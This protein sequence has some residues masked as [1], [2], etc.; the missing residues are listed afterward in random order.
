M[1]RRS[2]RTGLALVTVGFIAGAW[3]PAASAATIDRA[4]QR[5]ASVTIVHGV[6]GLVADV[7]VDGKQ[8]LSGFSPEQ[9]TAPLSLTPGKHRV[10]IRRSVSGANAAP[11]L[12][13]TLNLT[14]GEVGTAAVGLTSAGKP[15]LTMY[16]DTNAPTTSG[17][18]GHLAVRDIA[19]APPV[20]L[21]VNKKVVASSLVSPNAAST[22]VQAGSVPVGIDAADTKSQLV[23]PQNVP[24]LAGRST[25]LYLIGQASDHSLT[26]LAQTIKT[27]VTAAPTSVDT[28]Y[29]PPPGWERQHVL[30]QL[31]TDGL[32]AVL[33]LT[34]LGV[35]GAGTARWYRR[36]QTQSL[37]RAL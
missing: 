18:E 17:N 25:A 21:S 23:P 3:A 37:P 16:E 6:L 9:V 34:V 20:I 7:T 31:R 5:T 13:T 11:V 26:W 15:K 19:A 35:A 4:A 30:A 32:L 36:R 8:V 2:V 33:M 12:D 28:G 24:V 10:Q 29:G 27:P 14:P 1:L 22:V